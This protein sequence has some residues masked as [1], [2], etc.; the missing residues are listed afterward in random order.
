[1]STSAPN[2][3][4]EVQL[5]AIPWYQSPV[6]RAIVVTLITS[7][8][9]VAPKIGF[10]LG[11]KSPGDVENA[12]SFFF[13]LISIATGLYAYYQRKHSKL[14]PLT[15]TQAQADVHFATLSATGRPPQ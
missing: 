15:T 1:M 11:L 12:V 13:Q 10:A 3:L 8:V 9:A 2:V 6:Q 7:G 5:A 4:P 14:Q